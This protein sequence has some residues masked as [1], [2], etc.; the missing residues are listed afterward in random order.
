MFRPC[1][2]VG[3]SES[4]GFRGVEAASK[5]GMKDRGHVDVFTVFLINREREG[6]RFH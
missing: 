5:L 4:E 2:G 1:K 6:G 3:R